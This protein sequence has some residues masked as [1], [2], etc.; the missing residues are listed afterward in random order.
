LTTRPLAQCADDLTRDIADDPIYA[1]LGEPPR[2][3][4][5]VD[6]PSIDERPPA[7]QPLYERRSDEVA[8]GMNPRGA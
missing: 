2:F 8:L 3:I 4:D 7:M 6:S 5:T 1:E